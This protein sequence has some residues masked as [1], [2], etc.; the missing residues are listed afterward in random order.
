MF[1]SFKRSDFLVFGTFVTSYNDIKIIARR[2][3]GIRQI[4]DLVGRTVGTVTGASAQFF[5]DEALTLSGLD[6]T[7]VN[8]VHVHPEKTTS[9]LNEGLV[10]A[11]VVW[12][13]WVHL[14]MKELGNRVV[15]IPH[16]NFYLETFNA[17]TTSSFAKDHPDVLDKVLHGLIQA[18]DFISKHPDEAQKIVAQY[19]KKDLSIIQATWKDFDFNVI[20][21]QWFLNTLES[22]ARWAI[23][24]GLVAGDTPNYLDFI[25]THALRRVA[26][27]KVNIF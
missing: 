1:N 18:V 7:K 15:L 17:L 13:P 27:D 2:E 22:E 23:E 11:V 6:S 24:R 10:D 5:L 26:K 20:L 3:S 16:N 9:A 25:H 12:E 4:S 8:V 21:E 19:F 14:T